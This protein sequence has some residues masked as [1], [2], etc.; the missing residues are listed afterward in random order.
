MDSRPNHS[1][2][3]V[4]SRHPVPSASH[5]QIWEF[6]VRFELSAIRLPSGEIIGFQSLRDEFTRATGGAGVPPSRSNEKR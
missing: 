6:P 3:P 5:T 4:K 2:P 1:P